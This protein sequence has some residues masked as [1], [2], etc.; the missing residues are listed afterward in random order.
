[1][2]NS[3]S[4]NKAK[5]FY[6]NKI[7]AK[8]NVK[9]TILLKMHYLEIFLSYLKEKQN[10]KDL[11]DITATDITQFIDDVSGLKN[12][13]TGKPL[14][15]ST[16]NFIILTVKHFFKYLYR[17]DMIILNPASSLRFKYHDT[18]ITRAIL[19][20][21]EMTRLLDA[22]E[23]KTAG[24]RK[25]KALFELMYSSGLRVSEV[26]SLKIS[27]INRD[28]RT[29][30]IR[31]GKGRKDRVVPITRKAN[32]LLENYLGPRREKRDESVF[33][34][35]YSLMCQ[36]SLNRKFKALAISL[37]LYKPYLSLHSIRHSTATHLLENGADLRYVQEL[38]GHESIDTT[39]RYTHC[40]VDNLKRQYKQ[41]HPR[42]NRNYEEV[43]VKYK[44]DLQQLAEEIEKSR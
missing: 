29:I 13:N 8:G 14:A 40:L 16:M 7:Q 27:D 22:I 32:M 34:G 26:L 1:M 2:D 5:A 11:R 25:Y 24:G 38:L 10:A 33:P 18:G 31:L 21:G 36:R 9:R 19:T 3:L 42:E 28:S 4:Y 35:R 23:D 12:K 30:N 39:A 44:E 17:S 41:Y 20:P 15:G 43:D 6:Q 37:N